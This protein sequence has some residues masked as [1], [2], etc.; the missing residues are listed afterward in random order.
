MIPFKFFNSFVLLLSINLVFFWYFGSRGLI[1]K[2]RINT[3]PI[4]DFQANICGRLK[5]LVISTIPQVLLWKS[6]WF[7]IGNSFSPTG[8]TITI[9]VYDQSKIFINSPSPAELSLPVLGICRKYFYHHPGWSRSIIEADSLNIV[10]LVIRTSEMTI[11]KISKFSF[12]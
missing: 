6:Q 12:F 7:A 5:T 11:K 10:F 1:D 8:Q 3:G 9:Q 4:L 2:S